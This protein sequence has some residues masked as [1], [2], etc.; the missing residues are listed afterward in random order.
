MHRRTLWRCQPTNTL[1]VCQG[2]GT[3]FAV[4]ELI[5][6]GPYPGAQQAKNG[7]G[8]A[9]DGDQRMEEEPG[10]DAVTGWPQTTPP[11]LRCVS[12]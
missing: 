5:R 3:G 4:D 7:A 6:A 1:L 2:A 12:T 9:V 11:F 8:F 10:R